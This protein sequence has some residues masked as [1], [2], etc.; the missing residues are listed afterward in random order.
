MGQFGGQCL[1][2]TGG[3]GTGATQQPCTTSASQS[4]VLKSVTGGYQIT[5]AT[6]ATKCL[7]IANAS[8]SPGSQVMLTSCSSAGVPGEIWSAQAV[9]A[10]YTLIAVHSQQCADVSGMTMDVGAHVNQWTCNGQANRTVGPP[11][12]RSS[13]AQRCG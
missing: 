12:G 4:W 8:T 1:D 6:D 7:N 10:N 13:P 5:S 2:V 9:G 11:T 3:V